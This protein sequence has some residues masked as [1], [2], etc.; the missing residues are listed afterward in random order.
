[1]FVFHVNNSGKI[2][3]IDR[4]K[5]GNNLSEVVSVKIS[6]IVFINILQ[7]AKIQMLRISILSI[8]TLNYKS[9]VVASGQIPFKTCTALYFLHSAFEHQT[10]NV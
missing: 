7:K 4:F 1:M 10:K 5:Y 6:G 9:F 3:L 2:L 8:V